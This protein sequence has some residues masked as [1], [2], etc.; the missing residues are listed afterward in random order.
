MERKD[1]ESLFNKAK[2]IRLLVV[3]DLMLD[4]YLW[5]RTERI[6]PEA[7]VQVVEVTREDLR[8]GGAGN[9]IN[10]LVALGCQVVACSVIGG[11]DN[12]TL[13]QRAFTGKGVDFSGVFEDPMRATSR[14]TRVVAAN[15]Q[16]VRIDRETREPISGGFEER[17]CKFVNERKDDFNAILISDYAKGVL[18][19]KT[20][21]GIIS[22]ARAINIPV[23]V[24]PKGKD[25]SKYGGASILTPNRKEAEI[26]S[27]TT[28]RDEQGLKE[29]AR[30]ILE[31]ID[32]DALLI[33]RSEQGMSLFVS[34]DDPVNIPTVAREVFDVTGAGDTVLA[35]LGMALAC[36]RGYADA[37]QLANVA[38][39]IVVGKIGT[40]TVSPSEIIEAIGSGHRDTET[41]IKNLDVMVNVVNVEKTKGKRIVFT[42]GC[43]DLL[44][45][46][47]VKYLQKARSFGDL[48]I[49][50]LNSDSSVRR[51]KGEKRPLIGQAERA[52]ILAALDCVDYLVIFDEDTPMRLIEALKP[53]VLAK[54]GDYTPDRVVGK[55]IVESFGG[56]VELVEFVDGK[57]TTNIIEKILKNYG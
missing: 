41:K 25:F 27:G 2:D 20:L 40:S 7:P 9:V 6:S 5:G 3:G 43:F 54:G 55:D 48:L 57:S 4:E 53:D 42:N 29:T 56:R 30:I 12:G 34:G 33:T 51:L 17:I 14:K 19:E 37:A 16:I 49:L 8:I 15:Q 23:V 21:K 46:G 10:N 18:T 50:G 35:V 26:A 22:V 52:H 39:G 31:K 32:L 13:L 11:D 1:V 36:G 44:H 47:H 28:I 45:A 38:A 24:D